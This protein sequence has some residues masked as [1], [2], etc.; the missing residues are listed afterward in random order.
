MFFF[1]ASR[2]FEESYVKEG[3]KYFHTYSNKAFGGWDMC[4]DEDSAAKLQTMRFVKEV[5]VRLNYLDYTTTWEISAIWL[6]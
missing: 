2:I 6:A 3:S 4:I 1:S 5:E